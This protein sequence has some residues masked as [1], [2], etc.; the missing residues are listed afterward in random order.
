V[1]LLWR[2]FYRARPS[3]QTNI[4]GFGF[5]S[6]SVTALLVYLVPIIFTYLRADCPCDV[7]TGLG[8]VGSRVKN[9]DPV[10]SLPGA[11]TSTENY[12]QCIYNFFQGAILKTS[13]G[14]GQ[15]L[16]YD[17][18]IFMLFKMS[19]SDAISISEDERICTSEYLSEY[20]RGL[21]NV[22]FSSIRPS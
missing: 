7:T 16:R 5:G 12:A 22:V 6:V 15:Y 11:S 14:K 13:G 19:F 17:R 9:P 3:W 10:P 4:R 8:Q 1:R 21:F 18:I 20:S 2:Y